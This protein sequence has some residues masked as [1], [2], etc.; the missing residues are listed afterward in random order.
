MA[1]VTFERIEESDQAVVEL[2]AV[3]S[4]YQEV[5]AEPPYGEGPRDAAGFLVRARRQATR[6]GFRLVLAR[7]GD[8]VVGF[9]F[10]YWLPADTTWWNALLEPLEARFVEEDGRRTFNVAELAVRRGWRRQ[11]VAAEMHRLLISGHGAERITLTT[12][13]EPEAAPAR[14][15]YAAWGYRKVGLA[16]YGNDS[17]A[18]DVMVRAGG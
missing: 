7:E 11:G 18:Y 2:Q 9:A 6:D 1:G 17:P 3:V 16:R 8:E 4:A 12:R 5:Y 13:P 14:T 15:A 10:G